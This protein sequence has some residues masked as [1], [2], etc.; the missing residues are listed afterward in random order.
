MNWNVTY[1]E[2]EN[3]VKVTAEGAFTLEGCIGMKED[4]LARDF[5]RPGMNILI[6]YRLTTFSNL[7]L[8]V[9]RAASAFHEKVGKQIGNGRMAFLMKSLHDFGLA[10]QYQIITEDLVPSQLYVFLDE[11]KA[12]QWLT[13]ADL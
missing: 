10:R 11:D 2:N 6:D 13:N 8:D 1:I 9:L 4:F 12:V 7:K 5:W 3:Y